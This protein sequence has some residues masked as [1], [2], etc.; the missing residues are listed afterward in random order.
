MECQRATTIASRIV[1]GFSEGYL[2]RGF[3]RCVGGLDRTRNPSKRDMKRSV[4]FRLCVITDLEMAGNRRIER[5]VLEAIHGGA[6]VIQYRDK[7]A[8]MHERYERG[9]ALCA[10]TKGNGIPCI[11]ND[12]VD[13]V[14]AVKAD[15]VHL[16]QDDLPAAVARRILGEDSIVG[17]SV[18]CIDEAIRAESD[19][20]DYISIGPLY[21]TETKPDAGN[22][23]SNAVVR[24]IVEAVKI[25]VV[26]IGGINALNVERVMRLGVTGVAIVSAVM[27]AEHPGAATEEI[28]NRMNALPSSGATM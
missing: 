20:A 9:S 19:G 22:A 13:L 1:L 14:L 24:G 12:H 8:T 6:T 16:G 10:V 7:N 23:V 17:V 3:V 27:K 26:G 21:A 25:P 11:V 18:G 5:V 28:R 4:D 2:L 15:G